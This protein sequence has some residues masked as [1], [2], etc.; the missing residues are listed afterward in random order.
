M[1]S[2]S[3]LFG[4]VSY[5]LSHLK[6]AFR[7]SQ[8]ETLIILGSEF[9]RLHAD[10]GVIHLFSLT[11]I[12]PSTPPPISLRKALVPNKGMNGSDSWSNCVHAQLAR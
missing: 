1:D 7:S 12:R 4:G 9:Y 3:C 6:T 8:R 5:I 10:P 2:L 11:L